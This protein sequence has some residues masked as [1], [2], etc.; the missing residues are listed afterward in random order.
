VY[1]TVTSEDL[2]KDI[3]QVLVD[4]LVTLVLQKVA[5][6]PTTAKEA[7]PTSSAMAAMECSLFIGFVF[8]LV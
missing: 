4:D 7:A 3:S 6:Q 8:V 2:G 5:S 1:K